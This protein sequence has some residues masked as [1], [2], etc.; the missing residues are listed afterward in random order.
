MN[1]ERGALEDLT[2][3]D[4]CDEKGQLVGKLLGEMGARV[5]KVEPPD[6]D[7]ARN[8]GPFRNDIPGPNQSLNFWAF[9]T[10]KESITL[11]LDSTAGQGLLKKLALKA[12][13]VL[14]SFDPGYLDSLGLGYGDLSA[15]NAR[16]IMT[17]ITGFGQDGPYRDYKT[18]DIVGL[19]MSGIMHKLRV[20]RHSRHASHPSQRR[21]RIHGN[22]ALRSHR[23]P[24]C[25]QLA[26][27]DGRGSARRRVD[28]RSL[29]MHHR[30]GGTDLYLS[31]Q[32]SQTNDRK[33]TLSGPNSEDDVSDERWRIRKHIRGSEQSAPV[34][35]AG[36]LDGFG[37]EWQRVSQ[38]RSTGIWP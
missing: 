2:I 17:S 31:R 29:L 25:P 8:V 32:Y 16:L 19:A 4:L 3:L 21:T 13:V 1:T 38:T 15:L 27:H 7:A 18:S 5:V 20:R 12:D 36:H 22:R 33:A 37:G 11:D 6:G 14:E 28:S 23:H 35:V 26:G 24:R 9:N 30:V 10:A 34:V